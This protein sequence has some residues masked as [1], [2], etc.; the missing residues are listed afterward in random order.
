MV[1]RYTLVFIALLF[2]LPS[3]GKKCE[4]GDI[5]GGWRMLEGAGQ[6]DTEAGQP[7]LIGGGNFPYQ[8]TFQS[9][10]TLRVFFRCNADHT[11]YGE[12]EQTDHNTVNIKIDMFGASFDHDMDVEWSDRDCDRWSTDWS[13]LEGTYE[14]G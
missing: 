12:W 14:G 13:L 2:I 10:G 8:I 1:Y 11:Y 6:C 9:D 5:E 4:V 3:C 7:Y